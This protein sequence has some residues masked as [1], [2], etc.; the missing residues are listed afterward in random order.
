MNPAAC[1]AGSIRVSTSGA[2]KL[3]KAA[4]FVPGTRHRRSA[5]HA[6]AM[7]PK[8]G[9]STQLGLCASSDRKDV[10]HWLRSFVRLPAQTVQEVGCKSK[11]FQAPFALS[12]VLPSLED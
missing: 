1:A 2:D 8:R 11:T 10:I 5:V 12:R 4:Y 9:A 7:A 6:G 3:L